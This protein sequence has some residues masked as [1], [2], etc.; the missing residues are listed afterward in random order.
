MDERYLREH[1]ARCRSLAAKADEFTEMR[2]LALA[3]RYEQMLKDED[4]V[5]PSGDRPSL[6]PSRSADHKVRHSS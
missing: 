4:E 5:D 3:E 1:A 2:L 6:A